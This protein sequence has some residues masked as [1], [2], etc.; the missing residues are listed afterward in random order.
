MDYKAVANYII[1]IEPYTELDYEYAETMLNKK[2]DFWKFVKGSSGGCSCGIKTTADGQTIVGRNMDL[3]ISNKAAYIVRTKCP[4]KHATVGVAYN[5]M[6]GPDWDEIAEKGISKEYKRII[7]FNCTDVMNDAG[8]YVEINMRNGEA[9]HDGSS[10]FGCSGTN[11]KSDHK[12]C[13]LSLCR[14][15][16]ENCANVDEAIGYVNSLNLYTPASDLPWNFCFILGDKSGHYGLL[17]IAQNKVVWLD[18]QQAQTNFY[19]NKEFADVEE[20]KNGLARYDH[21]MNNIDAVQTEDEMFKL[22]DDITYFQVYTDSPKFDIRSE[23][24]GLEPH[25]TTDYAMSEEHKNEIMARNA[26]NIKYVH[27][28]S[29]KDLQNACKYWE[30]VF[31]VV[32]N[33]NNKTL[34]VRFFEDNERTFNLTI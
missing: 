34:R 19:I 4:G 15:I 33:C 8:L 31:T 28:V 29:R 12:V 5:Y 30:S 6:N 24:A 2:F 23:Y 20:I 14:Y 32:A 10:R 22:I 16:A 13:A 11:P 9:N 21:I 18:G 3:T 17:E 27:S 7:P 25:W 26:K 1:E